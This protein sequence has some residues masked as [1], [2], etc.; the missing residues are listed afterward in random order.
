MSATEGIV[1]LAARSTVL[2]NDAET[3]HND[4][5]DKLWITAQFDRRCKVHTSDTNSSTLTQQ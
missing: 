2:H 5:N 1:H 3:W 4:N